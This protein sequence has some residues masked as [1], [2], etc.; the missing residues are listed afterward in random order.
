MGLSCRAG[1]DGETETGEK[2]ARSRGGGG[3]RFYTMRGHGGL[4]DDAR[5]PTHRVRCSVFSRE[6]RVGSWN[7]VVRG[8]RF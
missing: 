6:R 8:D 2:A 5:S 7:R 4:G 3:G 1:A